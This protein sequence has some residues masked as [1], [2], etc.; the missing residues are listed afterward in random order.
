MSNMETPTCRSI[1]RHIIACVAA[2]WTGGTAHHYKAVR[3][4][5][6]EGGRPLPILDST[7]E[8]RRAQID[9]GVQV[10]ENDTRNAPTERPLDCVHREQP[11]LQRFPSWQRVS[12]EF[13]VN[14]D[15]GE[16]SGDESVSPQEGE[17]LDEDLYGASITSLL[18]DMHQVWL[19][20]KTS[21]CCLRLCR[22]A[23]TMFLLSTI[24]LLA[25]FLI[26]ETKI[27]ITPDCVEHMREVYSTYEEWMYDNHTYWTVHGNRRGRPGHFQAQRFSRLSSDMKSTIC[28]IPLAHVYFTGAVLAVWSFTVVVDLRAVISL[29]LLLIWKVDT[30]PSVKDIF[31]DRN[32]NRVLH[33]S[34][35]SGTFVLEGLTAVFK[36]VL[37]IVIFLPRV[38]L[39]VC[40]LYLG[41]RWLIA[42]QGLENLLLNAVALQFVVGLKDLCYRAVVPARTM[43]ATQDMIIRQRVRGPPTCGSYLGS[44]AW[45]LWVAAWV[46]VYMTS[47]QGVLPDFNWDV[48]SVC[49]SGSQQIQLVLVQWLSALQ[50]WP[51]QIQLTLMQWLSSI[52]PALVQWLSSIQPALVQWFSSSQLTL[53]KWLASSQLA[54][55]QWLSSSQLALMQWLSASQQWLSHLLHL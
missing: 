55:M 40:L 17:P 35:S 51:H 34:S 16:S 23:F 6:E 11:E 53:V 12:H 38:L 39:D 43:K 28:G 25:F 10:L 26:A 47:L 52:Q 48:S 4:D 36:I 30:V 7:P 20:P 3:Q 14:V 1:A 41:C 15:A 24:V 42:T 18:R 13:Y 54:L 22:V 29:S 50:R 46:Y 49:H 31:A 8:Q 21:T 5:V 2:R 32:G 45:S 37:V 9:K 27:M 44:F 33:L 19:G